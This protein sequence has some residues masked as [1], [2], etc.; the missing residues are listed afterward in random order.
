MSRGEWNSASSVATYRQYRPE[1]AT[2]AAL[3]LR[4]FCGPGA[5]PLALDVGCGTGQLSVPLSE[6]CGHVLAIDIEPEM[7]RVAKESSSRPN[8]EYRLGDARKLEEVTEGGIDLL[9]VGMAA[10]YFDC[11]AFY[12]SARRLVRP[13]GIIAL[14]GYYCPGFNQSG[15]E[16]IL[17]DFFERVVVCEKRRI[18]MK[19]LQDGY[20]SLFCPFR[21]VQTR[22]E[23][24]NVQLS[25]EEVQGLVAT[26]IP[27]YK[28]GAQN[29]GEFMQ[30]FPQGDEFT[31]RLC[32]FALFA[33]M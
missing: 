10:H 27:L 22:R 18:V 13:G 11:D 28:D 25:R 21:N 29:V 3:W 5:I 24:L 19:K 31:L 4:E 12:R 17:D 16:T 14:V 30:D 1:Y 33:R 32:V 26:N 9:T 20:G 23:I 8:I 6:F 7:I 2:T 15:L